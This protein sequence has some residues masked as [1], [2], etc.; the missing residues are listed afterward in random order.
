M[1]SPWERQAA[2]IWAPAARRLTRYNPPGLNAVSYRGAAYQNALRR[3]LTQLPVQTVPGEELCEP[4]LA[5]LNTE[6]DD[7]WAVA[8][9]HA[10]A[11]V[12]DVLTFYQ[13]RILNE[14]YLRTAT[15]PRSVVELARSTGYELR[16]G[17]SASTHLA[18]TVQSGRGEPPRQA[19]IPAGVAV[20][21]MSP[22]AQLPQVFETSEPFTARSEWNSLHLAGDGR[23]KTILPG[24]TSIRLSGERMD[25]KVGDRILF[26]E[27]GE[28]VSAANGNWLLAT[29]C[30]VQVEPGKDTTL[31]TWQD[32]VWRADPP[33]PLH[34]VRLYALRQLGS[35]FGYTQAAVD[36]L[37]PSDGRWWPAGIGL[38]QV[39]VHALVANPEGHLFA[40]TEQ[41][42]FR[43]IDSGVSWQPAPT[44]PL[45]RNVTALAVGG[46]TLY[47]G[48]D[49][50]IIS[51]SQDG[52]LNWT[53]MCG[54]S[55]VQPPRL[56]RKW[57]PFLFSAPL[58]KT[59]VRS[60]VVFPQRRRRLL[61][62]GT[63]NGA[64]RSA[65]Q[66]K[67]WQP[68]NFD[69]P[70]LDWKTGQAKTPVWA[71]AIAE[72]GWGHHLF[73]GTEGGVFRVKGSPLFWPLLFLS[74]ILV[75]VLRVLSGEESL[76]S[77][78]LARLKSV[79]GGLNAFFNTLISPLASLFQKI[80]KPV[81]DF[82]GKIPDPDT[83][84]DFFP[85]SLNGLNAL[86]AFLIDLLLAMAFLGL[87]Y[88][89]LKTADRFINRRKSRC[90]G[91]TVHALAVGASGHL[92]AGTPRGVYRSYSSNPPQ[93]GSWL[94]RFW[95]RLK[96]SLLR[97]LVR[98]W[99]PEDRDREG[100]DVR[101]LA[102][103]DSG[104][105]IAGTAT[106][107]LFRVDP[108]GEGWHRLDQGSNLEGVQAIRTVKTG[109]F[110]AGMPVKDKV[111]RRWCHSQVEQGQIDLD[112]VVANIKVPRWVVLQQGDDPQKIGLYR[113]QKS[114]PADTQDFNRAG[115]LTR[116]EVDDHTGL[117]KFDRQTTLVWAGFNALPLSDNQP[118][119]GNCLLL[120]RVVPGL[121]TGH[122][123][124][125][126]GK[127]SNVRLVGSGGGLALRSEDKLRSATLLDGEL[128]YL[129][130]PVPAV[131]PDG[132]QVVQWHLKNRHGFSGS[133]AARSGAFL[134]VTAVEE[135][136][137]AAE[138]AIIE[139]VEYQAQATRITLRKPLENVYDR[140][141]LTIYANV[142][143]ARHGRTVRDEVLGSGDGSQANQSFRLRQGPLSF[144][145]APTPSGVEADLDMRVNGLAWHLVLSLHGRNRDSR[146]YTVRQDARGNTEVIFG[147]GGQGARLPS[148][149]EQVKATY[150]V[151][152]GPEANMPAGS[153]TML[154][155]ALP[156]IGSVTN[157]L[158]AVG[159][160][161]RETRD[162]ARQNAPFA[163]R[164]M[165]RIVSLTD[166]QDFVQLYAGIGRA[167]VRLLHAGHRDVLHITI[168]D[169]EGQ[170]VK[171]DS[172]LYQIVVRAIAEN[173]GASEPR[174][175]VDSYE[176]V[177]FNLYARL[178]VDRDH[179]G[180]WGDLEADVR[181]KIKES[182][183]YEAR[184]F[185]QSVS[186][187]ELISLVQAIP[188]IVA[189]QLVHLYPAA[190]DPRL[191]QVLEASLARWH[192]GSLLPAQM[193][194]VNNAPDGFLLDLEV[195]E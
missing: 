60:L 82:I 16:P 49:E 4:P 95:A 27:D 42:V 61:V 193:L 165:G 113:V 137:T 87:L 122:R 22:A 90:L 31:I 65:D 143:P 142:V 57:L 151:G 141:S 1:S 26:V 102:V 55:V 54:E 9:V 121:E 88:Y 177:Y 67:T 73:V 148:G 132:D 20:Q 192:A 78:L 79:P 45:R 186:A 29:V 8:L 146:A 127:R 48:T 183:A 32:A 24:T 173:R 77:Y 168:A 162:R 169:R 33:K 36:T 109:T 83:W 38:P 100:P 62:A 103:T 187:C 3:M 150:C 181:R 85:P 157:P 5:H 130:S 74:L 75:A 41:D 116:L 115:K 133:V 13:E 171:K 144:R 71:L 43:S 134:L 124:I 125:F 56:L 51:L 80:F 76:V 18:F 131:D 120:E 99:P 7:D 145:Y 139:T 11:T 184:Q 64:F 166:F 152:I 191:D 63:D 164:T 91:L 10:W 35:L 12:T 123:L 176:P 30:A 167:Q 128:L 37:S 40:G 25:P 97:G 58:P 149:Y 69:L 194:L 174:V 136:E 98:D 111:E 21:G 2:S 154:Q 172:D 44:G 52:G 110:A 126:A 15:E 182:F 53:A 158:P 86:I 17:M 50:G 59:V 46:E 175:Y 188:G 155:S 6:A 70:G 104:T 160:E 140:L 112:Q 138:V 101:A 163:A 178:L 159:G 147:D 106:G 161:D 72:R 119:C 28:S 135:D 195:A 96:T 108:D 118:V 84:L 117:E 94:V 156:G 19:E 39:E 92:F 23:L 180:S 190:E 170:P 107:E 189:V 114:V 81:F 153:L 93:K 34:N 179:G 185:G 68:C 89:L 14:G 105:V 47:A 66:G 129:L